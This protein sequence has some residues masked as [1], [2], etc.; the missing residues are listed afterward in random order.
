MLWNSPLGKLR[1]QNKTKKKL[2]LQNC[3]SL[4]LGLSTTKCPI[5]VT[6]ILY[7]GV[8]LSNIHSTAAVFHKIILK[9]CELVQ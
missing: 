3:N 8:D 1:K 9:Q 7:L 5:N 4:T 2:K 6:E